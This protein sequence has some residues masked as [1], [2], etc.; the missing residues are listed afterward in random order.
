MTESS[1]ET[2]DVPGRYGRRRPR[3]G[4]TPEVIAAAGRRVIE[5]DGLNALSMRAVAAEL[6]TAA[7]SLYRHVA[8]RDALLLAILEDVAAGMPVEV[9][10][11]TPRARL[12]ARLLAA[13]DYLGR[14]VWVVHVLVRGELVAENA[15]GYVNA[16]LTD[17]LAAGL[18][19]RQARTALDACWHLL[20]G[21]L[22]SGHPLQPPVEP[23]QRQRAMASLD[24]AV[25]PALGAIREAVPGGRP[26]DDF[27]PAMTALLAGLLPGA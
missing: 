8:D 23:T 2:D 1:G 10:G 14:N 27:E 12:T 6:E 5:R 20:V 7:P 26:A 25:Y 19:P 24:P 16:C 13:H 18:S 22:L 17:F 4:F 9:E 3:R 11:E 15:F 21:E